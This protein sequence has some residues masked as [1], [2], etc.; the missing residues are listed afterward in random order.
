PPDVQPYG[1]QLGNQWPDLP[2]RCGG[3]WAPERG[4]RHVN[5]Q[6][7][8]PGDAEATETIV[9]VGSSHSRQFIPA[10]LPLAQA[11]GAQVVNLTMDGCSYLAGTERWTYCEGYDEYVLEYLDAVNPETVMTT[12]TEAAPDAPSESLPEGT[13]GALQMILDRGIEVIAVRD[14]PRWEQDQYQC[15]EAVIDRGD[16]PADADAA[17][18]A[19][20]EDKLAPE[21]PAAPLAAL[22][23]PDASVTLLDLSPLICPDGRCAPVL[24]DTF[25]Y[26]DDNHLTRLF[27]E[28][29]LA[30]AVTR[31]L[32]AAAV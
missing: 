26:M 12:V 4:F 6:Q 21:S 32:E 19:D 15:A 10:V 16:T 29:T 24:G 31:E 18:G 17:C 20:V 30:P 22:S 2:E 25:V 5:C 11:R 13:D 1:W 23:G 27:V 28:Q 9:V 14:T 3:P 7:L 8:L